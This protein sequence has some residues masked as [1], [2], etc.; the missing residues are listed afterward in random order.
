VQAVA[1]AAG[2]PADGP[3]LVGALEAEAGGVRT[4]V[5]QVVADLDLVH[6]AGAL[7]H[8]VLSG[9][10]RLWVPEIQ[11]WRSRIGVSRVRAPRRFVPT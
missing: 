9:V 6:A 4:R 5:H 2:E 10:V 1:V 7:L 3:L 8:T 11:I